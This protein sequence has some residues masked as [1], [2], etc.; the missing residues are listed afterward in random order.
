M[1]LTNSYPFINSLLD[2]ISEAHNKLIELC[3]LSS[4][5]PGA[6]HNDSGEPFLFPHCFKRSEQCEDESG[7]WEKVVV[8]VD[9]MYLHTPLPHRSHNVT[10][11]KL[12]LETCPNLSSAPCTSGTMR[13]IDK[14]SLLFL[15]SLLLLFNRNIRS[16][17][18]FLTIGSRIAEQ[19]NG[20]Q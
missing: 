9:A 3:S 20:R 12:R 7:S 15:I 2:P 13:L 10:S 8:V 11:I 14:R 5:P 18:Q 19:N 1:V 16:A 6:R 4:G 17:F